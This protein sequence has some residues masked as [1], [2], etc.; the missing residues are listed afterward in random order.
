MSLPTEEIERLRMLMEYH[1]DRIS[2]AI[3]D[4]EKD[5]MILGIGEVEGVKDFHLYP[6]NSSFGRIL[7]SE[8]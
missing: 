8:E 2:E 6:Y 5:G 3:K 1:T 4:A 7:W